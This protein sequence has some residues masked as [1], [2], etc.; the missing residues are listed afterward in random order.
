MCRWLALILDLKEC[1]G[2]KGG[3]MQMNE[4]VIL[5]TVIDMTLMS[6]CVRSLIVGKTVI[7]SSYLFN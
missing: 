1:I 5:C 6:A 3:S 4:A 2:N 7:G